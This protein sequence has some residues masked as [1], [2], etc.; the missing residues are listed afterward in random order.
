MLP[1]PARTLLVFKGSPP[2]LHALPIAFIASIL[3]KHRPQV[4]LPGGDD[5]RFSQAITPS[6]SIVDTG[7][8]LTTFPAQVPWWGEGY[9]LWNMNFS[10]L[11]AILFIIQPK[12][13]LGIK[14]GAVNN[15]NV[16]RGINQVCPGQTKS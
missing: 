16:I 10:S 4:V 9:S 14:G 2:G 5:H 12:T 6:T 8:T 15:Y 1:Q 7:I 13:L 11:R 3:T